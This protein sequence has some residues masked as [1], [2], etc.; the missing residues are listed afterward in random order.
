MMA[1]KLKD[2]EGG[3]AAIAFALQ[4]LGEK[5]KIILA[6]ISQ[7]LH[8]ERQVLLGKYLFCPV[9]HTDLLQVSCLHQ[10]PG[11]PEKSSHF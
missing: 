9:F 6:L 11:E 4:A 7:S 5:N 8:L 3:L 2:E 1:D 10:L